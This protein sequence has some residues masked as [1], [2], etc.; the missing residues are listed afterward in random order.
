M[1]YDRDDVLARTDLFAL[2]DELL[3]PH[4]GRGPS[5]SWPCPEPRHGTQTGKTPPLTLF[6]SSGGD[7]RWRCHACSAGGTAADLVMVT[8]NVGFRNAI[9]MLARRAGV[10]ERE[11]VR[12]RPAPR[13]RLAVDRPSVPA[14]VSPELE[15]H[16]AA[17]EQYLWSPQGV[18]M[19]RWLAARGLR[20]E[21]LLANRVGADPGPRALHRAGGLPRRGRAV[22]LPVLDADGRPTYFQARYLDPAGGRKYDNPA[23]AIVGPSPRLADIRL[24]GPTREQTTVLLCEG[25]PDALT[26]AQSGYRA[27]AVLGAG[28]P[29]ERLV[30][31]LVGRFPTETLVIAFDADDRGRRG[32]ERLAELLDGAGAITRTRMLVVPAAGGDLNAWAVERGSA[33]D[34]QLAGAVREAREPVPPAPTSRT[35]SRRAPGP[36]V[37]AT[38]HED[39]FARGRRSAEVGSRASKGGYVQSAP[40]EDRH[41]RPRRGIGDDAREA[42]TVDNRGTDVSA[43]PDHRGRWLTLA[44]PGRGARVL[45]PDAPA[46]AAS[47]DLALGIDP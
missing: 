7:E 36:V 11:N 47:A 46:A 14:V 29:D 19:Q 10:L 6:R 41:H 4:K 21:V 42:T 9:D 43:P 38:G 2:A 17:C 18:P 26:V 24:P 30:S 22:I 45:R 3:G 8:Q 15:R 37:S 5:A 25:M 1:P 20:R 27:T 35:A 12:L 33:F 16:V 34:Q 40:D 28:L 32:G 13:Q 23:A 31:E 39:D 44:D